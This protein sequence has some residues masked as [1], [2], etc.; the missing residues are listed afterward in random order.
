[1]F[2]GKSGGLSVDVEEYF[3]EEICVESSGWVIVRGT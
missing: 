1:M 2:A 3:V